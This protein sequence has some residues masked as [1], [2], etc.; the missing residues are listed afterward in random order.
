[1]DCSGDD[2]APY[3]A[4]HA[5]IGWAAEKWAELQAVA[6]WDNPLEQMSAWRAFDFFYDMLTRGLGEEARLK[7]DAILGDSAAQA[8]LDRRRG[9]AVEVAGFEVA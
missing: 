4:A 8:E 3:G 1:M 7:V 9:V 6:G 2:G 5:L